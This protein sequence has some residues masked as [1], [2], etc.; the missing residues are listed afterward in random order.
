MRRRNVDLQ[1]PD[2]IRIVQ[3]LA[4]KLDPIDIGLKPRR[5]RQ[6][7]CRIGKGKG[8]AHWR[9][10]IR[11]GCMEAPT[12]LGFFPAQQTI[13]TRNRQTSDRARV[14]FLCSGMRD[15]DCVRQHLT[16]I[17]PTSDRTHDI[18]RANFRRSQATGGYDHNTQCQGG[19]VSE[20]RCFG[21]S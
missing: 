5:F 20:P 4:A 2:F 14:G 16:W 17:G 10:Q 7:S 11:C 13:M 19:Q 12:G 21:R 18:F 9:Y 15:Q 6:H 8:Q 3:G 1:H